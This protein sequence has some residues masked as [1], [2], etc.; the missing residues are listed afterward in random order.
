MERP[1]GLME[2]LDRIR[3][4]DRLSE[5]AKLRPEAT[6][7]KYEEIWWA[8]HGFS[9]NELQVRI[10]LALP[11]IVS[12]LMMKLD[13]AGKKLLGLSR[14]DSQSDLQRGPPPTRWRLDR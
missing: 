13:F 5:V 12:R 2:R 14:R 7:R 6:A 9:K 8:A 10:L 1:K 11:L 3:W 4:V